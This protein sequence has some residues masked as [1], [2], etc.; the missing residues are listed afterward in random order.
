MYSPYRATCSNSRLKNSSSTVAKLGKVTL[1]KRDDI[2]QH[3]FRPADEH[4]LTP[5]KNGIAAS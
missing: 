5:K 4:A 2:I 1:A 3:W